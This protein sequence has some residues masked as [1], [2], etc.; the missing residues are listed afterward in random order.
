[1]RVCTKKWQNITCDC[2]QVE[3][4]CVL[5]AAAFQL[6]CMFRH[7]HDKKLGEKR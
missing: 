2:T 6:L 7:L 5:T 1:M 4:M 3:G